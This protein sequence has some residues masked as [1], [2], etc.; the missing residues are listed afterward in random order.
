MN[1]YPWGHQESRYLWMRDRHSDYVPGPE[2]PEQDTTF[3]ILHTIC[4]GASYPEFLRRMRGEDPEEDPAG[5]PLTEEDDDDENLAPAS[6]QL[7]TTPHITSLS[8]SSPTSSDIPYPPLPR[9]QPP[10]YSLLM[11]RAVSYTPES[12]DA[13]S[14]KVRQSGAARHV[15]NYSE[16]DLYGFTDHVRGRSG[17]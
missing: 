11:L 17:R 9:P 3:T 2:E 5:Y 12:L 15:W 1:F 8:I 13:R 16:A 7:L 4:S 6:L 14:G 10:P